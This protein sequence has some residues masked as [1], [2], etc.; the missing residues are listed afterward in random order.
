[1][2]QLSTTQKLILIS[3]FFFISIF[4]FMLKLPAVFREIDKDLHFFFYFILAFVINFLFEIKSVVK[5]LVINVALFFFGVGIEIA[6]HIS[7]FFFKVRIHGNF[8]PADVYFNFKGI[9]VFSVIWFIYFF[10]TK[11]SR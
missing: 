1:M 11:K 2:R 9:F 5:H 7:N 8:D 4:G 10:S 6:Q 3:F